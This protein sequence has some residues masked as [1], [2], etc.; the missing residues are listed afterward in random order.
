MAQ[1]DLWGFDEE[2]DTKRSVEADGTKGLEHL[3]EV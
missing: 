3:P 1:S 2:L